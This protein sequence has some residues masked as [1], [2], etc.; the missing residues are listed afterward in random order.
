[1]FTS[2]SACPTSPVTAVVP[3]TYIVQ[4]QPDPVLESAMQR[5]AGGRI[6]D[7]QHAIDL[8]HERRAARAA[9][10]QAIEAQRASLAYINHSGSL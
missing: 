10:T 9:D 4:R 1:M 2:R 3:S 6:E 8:L 5:A 7:L